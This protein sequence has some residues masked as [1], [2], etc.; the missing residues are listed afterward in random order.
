MSINQISGN[1]DFFSAF[2]NTTGNNNNAAYGIFSGTSSAI[3]D[4]SL[5]KSG[6]YKKLLNAYYA[7]TGTPK[8]YA[9][10]K[11]EIDEKTAAT[12]SEGSLQSAKSGAS[13]LLDTLDRLGKNSLYTS[14]LDEKGKPVYDTDKIKSAVK[15][16]V[17]KYNSFIDS[18][19]SLNS[20]KMLRKTLEVIKDTKKNAGLLSDI[21]IT[22]GKDNK[23][24]LDEEKFKKANMSTAST[25]F[26][27]SGSYGS[28]ILAKTSSSYHIA[29]SAVYKNSQSASPYTYNGSYSKI[30]TSNIN[31]LNQYL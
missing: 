10:G 19:S 27:G 21:G 1:N 28:G 2:F 18:T 16:Y 30:N 9:S 5:I 25:L 12:D 11:A 7:K 15:D 20:T 13:D 22:I 8:R 29:N 4:M 24:S 14:K 23:L 26:K 6:S 31:K 3:S 17:D